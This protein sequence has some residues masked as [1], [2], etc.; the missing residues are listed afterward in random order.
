MN[1]HPA[2]A[3]HGSLRVLLDRWV[4]I[5]WLRPID[6]AVAD[7]LAVHAPTNDPLAALA[8]ALASHQSGS[9]H[10]CLDLTA[11]KENPD[12]T[13]RMPPAEPTGAGSEA[14]T[15]AAVL[16]GVSVADWQQALSEHPAVRPLAWREDH[17]AGDGRPL[18][19][20]D[21]TRPQLY[22]RRYW[23]VE[24][25]V[26]A[27]LA[28]RTTGEPAPAARVRPILD[29]LYPTVRGQGSAPDWQ[30]L[31]C[32]L[33]A[34]QPFAI[35]TGGPGTGK[36]TTVVRLLATLT[37]L[38]L[39]GSDRLGPPR[40]ALCAPTGKA[41]ARLSESIGD[42]VREIAALD[43][44]PTNTGFEG[45][46]WARVAAHLPDQVRTIHRL[47]GT[48][49]LAERPRH[50]RDNPL[51]LDI[52]VVDEAS[53]IG[54]E[55]M[56]QLVD[57]LPAHCRL[58]MLGD[59]DQ[60]AS[61]EAGAVLG[62][63]CRHAGDSD[64][65]DY[66]RPVHDYLEAATGQSLP[67]APPPD[68]FTETTDAVAAHIATLRVSHRFGEDSA[69]GALARAVNRGDPTAATGVLGRPAEGPIAE[70]EV[71][72][73][74]DRA[75][76]DPTGGFP[77]LVVDGLRPWLSMLAERTAG[78][79]PTAPADEADVAELFRRHN[80]FQLLCALR[81]G[82]AGVEGLNA[83]VQD[84]L[85]RDGLLP[86]AEGMG[87]STGWYA[88]RPV[89]VTRNDAQLNLANGDMGLTLPARLESGE[90][91]LR[92]VF[93]NDDPNAPPGRRFHWVS[94]TRLTEV[95][96]AFALTV[97]KSQGSEFTRVALVMPAYR[98]PILTRELLYTAITRARRQFTLVSPVR[99]DDGHAGQPAEQ[100]TMVLRAAIASVTRRSGH[101][102]RRLMSRLALDKHNDG[103][104][105]ENG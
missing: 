55:L 84:C 105:H 82:P 81:R 11:V 89:I 36:T 69:I 28:G 87:R 64:T 20:V 76:D 12:L 9:G 61:V 78:F 15:P 100:A 66:P 71:A 92:V 23:Q 96:T 14:D 44:G 51:D 21:P 7:F 102:R 94:P 67:A 6:R 42:K 18:V 40:I 65:P 63:L 90:T 4:G 16:D 103:K 98:N 93:P 2:L 33:A 86:A 10:V 56:A 1:R 62:E 79:D 35:I 101:L 3:D 49:P 38:H 41:A 48:R 17:Q 34:Y 68:L 59:K 54:M 85:V 8:G 19:L 74:L 52:V 50:H 39:D 75:G 27:G 46:S 91:G 53:M 60:L 25:R 88:G 70:R 83:R 97:H 43:D 95:E 47:I 31:A 26:A 80:D 37:A 30:K 45:G 24:G 73:L 13:L 72:W 57:A 22:L 104:W 29:A 77:R 58:V 5:G 32:A 99:P